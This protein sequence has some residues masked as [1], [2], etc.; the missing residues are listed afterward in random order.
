MKRDH[1]Q[2]VGTKRYSTSGFAL[3]SWV[4]YP[5]TAYS[6][7]ATLHTLQSHRI[8]VMRK[9]YCTALKARRNSIVANVTGL[10]YCIHL[11]SADSTFSTE[12]R[13]ETQPA[14]TAVD[15]YCSLE[16]AVFF[17]YKKFQYCCTVSAALFEALSYLLVIDLLVEILPQYS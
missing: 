8:S 14:Q 4:R 1:L 15:T 12:H 10:R 9:K 6:P 7:L 2:S 5:R 16:Y 17:F 13:P 11:F 3:L